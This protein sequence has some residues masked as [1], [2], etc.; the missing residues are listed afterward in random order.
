MLP[1]KSLCITVTSKSMAR[2]VEK[3]IQS[4]WNRKNQ[5]S[6]YEK[7]RI[8]ACRTIFIKA[9]SWNTVETSALSILKGTESTELDLKTWLKPI[10]DKYVNNWKLSINS[11]ELIINVYGDGPVMHVFIPKNPARI[12]PKRLDVAFIHYKHPKRDCTKFHAQ[13][14]FRIEPVKKSSFIII[15][16]TIN[17][18]WNEFVET[19]RI[20]GIQVY[21]DRITDRKYYCD[22]GSFAEFYMGDKTN[23]K[24][25]SDVQAFRQLFLNQQGEFVAHIKLEFRF[26]R[27]S[28][29]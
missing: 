9:Y 28:S 7:P 17:N 20:N 8:K 26:K 11:E 21:L 5:L 27:P 13:F 23:K 3:K 12:R 29:N 25:Y 1:P 24:H 15:L 10:M 19:I 16:Q 6:P 14:C 18:Y 2:K 4:R 22:D